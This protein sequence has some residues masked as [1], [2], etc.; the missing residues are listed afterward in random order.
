MSP[1]EQTLSPSGAVPG[2]LSFL[3]E[4][5]AGAPFTVGTQQDIPL[6]SGTS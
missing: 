4:E 6:P 5:A 1:R 3:L 2:S